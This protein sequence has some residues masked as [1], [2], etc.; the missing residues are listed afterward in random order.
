MNAAVERARSE[1]TRSSALRERSELLTQQ[2]VDKLRQYP[3]ELGGNGD[4]FSL[5]LARLRP[6]VSLFR[7]SFRRWLEQ[8]GLADDDVRDLTLAASEACAN[9]VEH[10]VAARGAFEVEAVRRTDE[11]VVVVRDFGGWRPESLNEARGRGLQLI[12]SLMTDVDVA[13][14]EHGTEIVMRRRLD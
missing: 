14:R 10:P 6:T 3:G 5:R 13:H 11:I 9:A 1:R 4:V 12:R 2:L 8:R 7:H